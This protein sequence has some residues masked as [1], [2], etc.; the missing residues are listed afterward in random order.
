MAA[1]KENTNAEKW[2]EE[3]ANTFMANALE[4]SY[5]EDYDFIGEIAKQLKVDKGTFDYLI[6]KFDSLKKIKK[7]ILSNCEA[8]CFRNSKKGNINTAVGIV[9]LK[10]NHGWTD[11]AETTV[12][13][14]DKPLQVNT[15]SLGNGIKPDEAST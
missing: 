6:S 12:Q 14:G 9:N 8:N 1:P 2:T 10:S 7:H 13:G 5:N 11:R 4:L 3:E 15:I